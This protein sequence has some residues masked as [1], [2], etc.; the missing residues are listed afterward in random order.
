MHIIDDK[1]NIYS[2]GTIV[3]LKAQ[4]EVRMLI[5]KYHERI[6][7]CKRISAPKVKLMPYFEHELVG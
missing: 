5:M 4:P 7:F 2:E 3:R 6:Y 1:D